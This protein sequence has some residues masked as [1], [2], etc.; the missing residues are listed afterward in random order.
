MATASKAAKSAQ[1]ADAG[2]TR[3]SGKLLFLIL[4]VVLLLAVAGGGAAWFFLGQAQESQQADAPK[5]A[6]GKPPV[7]MTLDTF[8]VNLQSDEGVQQFLQVNL[9][10][11]VGSQ[12]TVDTIKLHMPQVRNRVLLL[13]SSKRASEILTV[14]GK[15]KLATEIIEQLQQPFATGG[16]AHDV[17]DVFF[18]SFVVQ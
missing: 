15:K 1:P 4:G 14:D 18:T 16:A 13:L 2:Q 17:S 7:F 11:Q 5:P 10:L 6:P 8:T 12:A 9:S 3:K